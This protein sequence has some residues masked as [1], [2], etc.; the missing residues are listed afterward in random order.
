MLKSNRILPIIVIAQFCCTSLW[1]A[2]N[3]IIN[4]I[5]SEFNL[6]SEVALGYLTSA[7]QFGFIVGTLIFAILNI[8]DHFSPSKVFFFSAIIA[9]I[10]N[11]GIL[12]QANSLLS[13]SG[14]RFFTGFFLAGIYPVGMKIA[15]DYYKKG[16]GKSLSFL[17]G[18][19]VLGTAL[20][21]LLNQFTTNFSWKLVII[22]TSVLA[23]I[24]GFLIFVYV[25]DGPYRKANKKVDLTS[26][27]SIFKTKKFR[28]VAFGYFGHMWE[29][30]TFWAFVPVILKNYNTYH[31]ANLNISLLSFLII[32][33]GSI[34]CVIGGYLSEKITLKKTIVL[35]LSLS[36]ICCLVSPIAFKFSS[37]ILILFL[38]IWGMTVIMDSPLLSTLVAQ[39]AIPDKKGTALT[40]VNCIGYAIT[41]VSIQ[42]INTMLTFTDAKNVFLVLAIGPILGVIALIKPNF[43]GK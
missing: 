3:G 5:I 31:Q 39:N 33:I 35:V 42:L 27:L 8:S 19:L 38:L 4:N 25:P 10:F 14:F 29:L 34:A 16:L 9:G 41:I 23:I 17:V 40:I 32:G 26:F 18:A 2:S 15:A 7:I 12:W 6:N 20:P 24:G 37:E 30:Y 13:L 28:L 43:S 11:L 1:F 21:H 36:G 22:S